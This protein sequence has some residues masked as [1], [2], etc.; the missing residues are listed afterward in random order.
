MKKKP[1]PVDLA[2]K[3]GQEQQ[4]AMVVDPPSFWLQ[5][6]VVGG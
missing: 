2:K 1:H 4:D 3:K 6:V 5:W